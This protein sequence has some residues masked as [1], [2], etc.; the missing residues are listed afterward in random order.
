MG[1]NFITCNK[2]HKFKPQG[3]DFNCPI[4]AGKEPK[5]TGH[6][7]YHNKRVEKE[8]M[9]FPSQ[10]QCDYYFSTLLPLKKAG[11]IKEIFTEVTF[12][13]RAGISYRADFMVIWKGSG[14]YDRIEIIDTKGVLTYPFKM[15]RKL[16]NEIHPNLPITIIK[17]ENNA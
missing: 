13:L 9:K 17:K 12:P 10:F 3:T 6:N 2:G 4:C 7:K 11:E 5:K 8:G 14:T 15:K 16:W 1:I